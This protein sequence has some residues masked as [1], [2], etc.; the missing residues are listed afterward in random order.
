MTRYSAGRSLLAG[1][2]IE[3]RDV[4][5]VF[6]VRKLQ[7]WMALHIESVTHGWDIAGT[8]RRV[9]QN[10]GR[11]LNTTVLH[12]ASGSHYQQAVSLSRDVNVRGQ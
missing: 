10:N 12:H 3:E 7:V 1:R 11:D 4:L 5:C 6:M 2:M 9:A 8:I